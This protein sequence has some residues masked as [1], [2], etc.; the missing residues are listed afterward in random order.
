MKPSLPSPGDVLLITRNASVQF[1]RPM[2]F[3]V[4]KVISEWVTYHGWVWLRGYQLDE[5]GNATDKRDIYVRI[6]GL[7]VQR[8]NGPP[9]PRQLGPVVQRNS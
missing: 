2:T 6:N 7:Q 4:I 9:V 1:T 5:Q 3:R 8:L